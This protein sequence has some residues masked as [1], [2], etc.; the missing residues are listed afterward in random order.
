MNWKKTFDL[1]K[2]L[3]NSGSGYRVLDDNKNARNAKS[4]AVIIKQSLIFL[5]SVL[6]KKNLIPM[7]QQ[8]LLQID[9][10]AH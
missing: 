6:L 10:T 4:V 3:E 5:Q 7:I 8:M 1:A 2:S 9:T